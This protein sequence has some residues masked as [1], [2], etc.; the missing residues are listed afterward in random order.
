MRR[1]RGGDGT[2]RSPRRSLL[3]R[4]AAVVAAGVLAVSALAACSA[5]DAGAAGPRFVTP[6][7]VRYSA[8][9]W[10]VPLQLVGA[11]PGA[12][13]RVTADLVTGRGTWTS[14]ATYTVP[15]SGVLDLARARPQLAPFA[16]ADSAGLFWSL[17]GPKL[18]AQAAARQWMRDSIA[19]TLTASADGR[20][21]AS[22]RFDLIGL[23]SGIAVRT[24][25]TR[26]LRPAIDLRLPRQTHED[27]PLGTFYSAASLERPQ[28]PAVLMLDDPSEGASSEFTAPLI[29]Q[30]GASV[31]SIPV[32]ASA[33]GVRSTGIISATTVSAVFDW[34]E[35]RPDIQHDRIFVYGSGV[36]EQL[37]VWAATRFPSRTYGL[38]VASGSPAL[39][40]LPAA[41]VAP[42]YE[43][44]DGLRCLPRSG[45]VV[46]DAIPSI[47]GIAGPVVIA[48]GEGDT[49]LPNACDWQRA[50]AATRG[51]RAGDATIYAA[52]SSHSVSVPP[53]LPIDLPASGGQPTERARVAFW[54]AV[55]RAVLKA[56]LG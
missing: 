55:G 39:L 15:A 10:P 53:G 33:D 1:R 20:V 21:V 47:D 26:D 37:A 52:G 19:V 11:E 43:D 35:Q 41:Q 31:L 36:A 5:S 24:L 2:G 44:E 13:L 29:A 46:P 54:D 12:R 25:Y 18:G 56:V 23:A 16:D 22:R 49:V 4:V 48:C 40:C 30:L 14:G 51:H 32:A 9:L 8:V 6:P 17:R 50:L 38:F 42:A 7:L 3:A 28:T 34:L 45:A 27:V